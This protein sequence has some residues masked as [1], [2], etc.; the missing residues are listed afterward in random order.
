MGLEDQLRKTRERIKSVNGDMDSKFLKILYLAA[1]VNVGGSLLRRFQKKFAEDLGWRE[2]DLTTRNAAIFGIAVP[3]VYL[4]INYFVGDVAGET[5]QDV[6]YTYP[7]LNYLQSSFRIAYSQ[8]TGKAIGAASAWNLFG[9]PV[10]ALD[11][12]LEDS[13]KTEKIKE[14]SS[15]NNLE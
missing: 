13:E 2:K 9:S 12:L 8:I 14:D 5:V 11:E 10:C 15:V 4:A 6:A 1:I 7:V 3:T